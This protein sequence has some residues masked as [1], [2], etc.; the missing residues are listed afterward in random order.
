[1]ERMVFG[2]SAK[3]GD[4]CLLILFILA[5]CLVVGMLVTAIL[6]TKDRQL[7]YLCT[8]FKLTIWSFDL[9]LETIAYDL[10]LPISK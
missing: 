5:I 10:A 9:T 8:L 3:D 6:K 7:W 1:M 4:K 2:I